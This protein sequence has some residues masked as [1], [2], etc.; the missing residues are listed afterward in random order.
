M[1]QDMAGW[2]DIPASKIRPGLLDREVSLHKELLQRLDAIKQT[3]YVQPTIAPAIQGSYKL[4]VCIYACKYVYV[5]SSYVCICVSIS[6][7]TQ[8]VIYA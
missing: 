6:I 5:A 4:Q 7:S 1:V 8:M 2:L 3:I